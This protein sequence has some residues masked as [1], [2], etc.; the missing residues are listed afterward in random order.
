MLN[1]ENNKKQS[2]TAI[3]IMSGTSSDGL[4]LAL[5]RFETTCYCL[6]EPFG[7]EDNITGKHYI[8]RKGKLIGASERCDKNT[9]LYTE[10][11][12]IWNFKILKTKTVPYSGT[13][14]PERFIKAENM[15]GLGLMKLHRDFGRFTGDAVNNFIYCSEGSDT[16][17]EKLTGIK[18]DLI[19]SHGHTIFHRP[20]QG[21]TFQIGDGAEIAAITG[22][23]TI[24]DFRRL[25]VALGGQGAPLVP[26]G[27]ELLFN[28]YDFC[29]NLG[30]FANISFRESTKRVAFDI[31]PANIVLN[32]IAQT[33]GHNYDK[34]G[35]IAR[36]G[37]VIDKLLQSLENLEYYRLAGPRSLGKEWLDEFFMPVIEKFTAAPE[38]KMRTVCEH[39]ALRIASALFKPPAHPFIK[40]K[41]RPE[42]KSSGYEKYDKTYTAFSKNKTNNNEE[43]FVSSETDQLSS[44]LITGG[45]AKNGFL[46]ELIAAKTAPVQIVIPEDNLIDFKEAVV[47]AFL[48]VRR[49]RNE[50][51][52]LASVTGARKDN[53]GGIIFIA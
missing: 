7:H 4:D 22:I 2:Y 34:G 23:T 25:D 8:I 35:D 53:S 48:G 16:G 24:S 32:K 11:S 30:G 12:A 42:T 36:T 15:D 14:W 38:D 50:P 18:P 31:C 47:F 43:G 6:Q 5:C 28:Q 33:L 19:A 10:C 20:A 39:I 27:D 45:G 3:G 46:A 1:A 17:I 40:N 41:T 52:C 44:L 9:N 21:I 29:L 26:V 13:S 37:N 51:N 49:I